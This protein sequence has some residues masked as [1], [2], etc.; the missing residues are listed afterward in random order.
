MVMKSDYLPINPNYTHS[1]F[2]KPVADK[3]GKA[4]KVPMWQGVF[5]YFSQAL[6]AVGVIS[7]FGS[8]KHNEGK[9]PTAWKEYPATT[10]ADANARHILAEG[11]SGLY[12]LE[13]GYLHAAHAAWNALARLELLLEIWPLEFQASSLEPIER[14]LSGQRRI[15]NVWA[16]LVERRFP[17]TCTGRRSTDD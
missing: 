6:L 5:A 9:F 14:R 16:Y 8:V 7:K 10:Y 3:T 17:L 15:K 12:D 13:S 4:A 2:A 1:P 11:K